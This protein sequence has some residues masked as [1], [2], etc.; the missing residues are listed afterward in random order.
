MLVSYRAKDQSVYKKISICL[1]VWLYRHRGSLGYLNS[2][3]RSLVEEMGPNTYN[4]AR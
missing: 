1:F 2:M 4:M 3:T